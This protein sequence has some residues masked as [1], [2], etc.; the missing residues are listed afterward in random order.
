MV[1]PLTSPLMDSLSEESIL[2]LE[3]DILLR[4]SY[5]Q[6]VFKMPRHLEITNIQDFSS[7]ISDYIE[8]KV[9]GALSRTAALWPLIEQITIYTKSKALAS[10]TTI[11][12]LPGAKDVAAASEQATKFLPQCQS[13]W[14][15][16]DT[17]WC[18]SDDIAATFETEFAETR[19]QLGSMHKTATRI[20]TKTDNI[21]FIDIAKRMKLQESNH[22]YFH[23]MRDINKLKESI[24]LPGRSQ[25][26]KTL[27]LNGDC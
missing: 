15:V 10:G 7:R 16:T 9:Y 19:L 22:E 13:I 14:I 6:S 24:S 12:D 8:N 11:L 27:E 2:N 1:F 4:D 18:G 21:D 23:I 17:N 25:Y 20:C 3:V 5:V 26:R